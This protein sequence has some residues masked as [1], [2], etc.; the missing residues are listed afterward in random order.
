[1]KNEL[2][3]KKNWKSKV[4]KNWKKIVAITV[5]GVAAVGT[6]ALIIYKLKNG[7]TSGS[8]IEMWIDQGS[9]PYSGKL[10]LNRSEDIVQMAFEKVSLKDVDKFVEMLNPDIYEIS[11]QT[12]WDEI[13]FI[14][15]SVPPFQ[16]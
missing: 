7:D 15:D 16:V 11:E 8:P 2:K 10:C 3:M 9:G 14:R 13:I 5:A 4:K 12:E 6:G 1:M